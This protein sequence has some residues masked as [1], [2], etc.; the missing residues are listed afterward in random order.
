MFHVRRPTPGAAVA[1]CFLLAHHTTTNIQRARS[2]CA[3]SRAPIQI[4][5]STQSCNYV[6]QI[7]AYHPFDLLPLPIN[8]DSH[9]FIALTVLL[10]AQK[11]AYRD[12]IRVPPSEDLCAERDTI[13]TKMWQP[14]PKPSPASPAG[15]PE[16][17]TT[18]ETACFDSFLVSD[19]RLYLDGIPDP[20]PTHYCCYLSKM[21]GKRPPTHQHIDTPRYISTRRDRDTPPWLILGTSS[22]WALTQT[23]QT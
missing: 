5:R 20:H 17:R 22:F 3:V 23:R 14:Q 6:V 19:G 4:V 7:F 1:S 18:L 8:A 15:P 10:T 12:F 13:H 11:G 21:A 9:P 2:I 16:L